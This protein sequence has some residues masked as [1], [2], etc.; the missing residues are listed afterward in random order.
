MKKL[1]HILN[2]ICSA[3][4]G[5]MLIIIMILSMSDLIIRNMGYSVL[6]ILEVSILIVVAAIF[7]GLGYCEEKDG[8]VRV[9]LVL[10]R[11][12]VKRSAFTRIICSLISLPTI[13]FL[14]YACI[15]ATLI[16]YRGDGAFV[17][18]DLIIFTW[19]TRCLMS[20]GLVLYTIQIFYNLVIEIA[21]YRSENT[22]RSPL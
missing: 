7:L 15:R 9:T 18:G 16:A 12:P 22:V 2:A 13:I 17:A 10:D 19:P 5:Y 20:F 6:G 14:T 11:L 21:N 8:H 4:S 1:I 3:V